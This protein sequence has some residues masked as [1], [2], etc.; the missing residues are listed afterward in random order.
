MVDIL[1]S[2]LLP[3]HSLVITQIHSGDILDPFA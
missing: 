3:Y 2:P 1:N